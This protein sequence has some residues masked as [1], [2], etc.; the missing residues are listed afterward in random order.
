L[1]PIARFASD[2]LLFVAIA[3]FSTLFDTGDYTMR[4]RLTWL[5]IGCLFVIGCGGAGE[6]AK[7]RN[8]DRP[9]PSGELPGPIAPPKSTEVP[10]IEAPVKVEPKVEP[11]IEPKAEPKVETKTDPKSGPVTK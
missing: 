9:K 6:S 11:K 2:R 10:R 4:G 5:A 1:K 7:F 8:M 3:R